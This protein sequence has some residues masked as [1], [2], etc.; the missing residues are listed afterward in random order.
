M[1]GIFYPFKV[2]ANGSGDIIKS[3]TPPSDTGKLWFNI[4]GDYLLHYYDN[5]SGNWLKLGVLPASVKKVDFFGD[6]SGLSLYQLDGNANDTGG[7]YNGTWGG[8]ETYDNGK[9][10]QAA[11]IDTDDKWIKVTD[12]SPASISMWVYIKNSPNE[13]NYIYDNRKDKDNK[14]YVLHNNG[15]IGFGSGIDKCIMNGKEISSGSDIELNKWTH[16]YF[17]INSPNSTNYF[18]HY[19]DETKTSA[20]KLDGLLDQIRLFNRTLTNEEVNNLY[21]ND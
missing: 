11:V 20:Y 17:S 18:G 19:Y 7:V 14:A 8:T 15:K 16:L 9:F 10:G 21:T 4:G 5:T 2:Q 3:D 1:K 6:D 12:V 13:N